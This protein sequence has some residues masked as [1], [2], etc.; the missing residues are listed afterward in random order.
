MLLTPKAAITPYGACAAEQAKGTHK[1]GM[2]C[3][4]YPAA[5]KD[6][7]GCVFALLFLPLRGKKS[8]KV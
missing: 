5:P 3:I 1:V 2:L 8:S 7:E 6:S 4:F